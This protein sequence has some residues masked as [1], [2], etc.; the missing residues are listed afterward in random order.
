[1]PL[2]D[3]NKRS[4]RV[5]TNLQNLDLDTVTFA[6]IA[7]TGNTIAVE[8]MNE[9]EMRRLVLVNLARLVCAGE[10]TG[11]LEAGGGNGNEF[12]AELTK[13]NWDGDADPIRIMALAPFGCNDRQHTDTSIQDGSLFWF[14]FISPYTGTVS[15]L[16]IYMGGSSGATGAV[17]I[18]FYSD[19]DGVPQTFLGEF[20][21]PTNV[22]A[23][24]LTQTVSSA[25]V[26]LTRGTQFWLGIYADNW[27]SQ[28]NFTATDVQA[29]GSSAVPNAPNGV[30][31]VTSSMVEA[32][33]SGNA[34]ITDWTA[35]APTT[36]NPINIG[37]KF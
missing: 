33:S 20:V 24:T 26:D 6:N 37:V 22:G 23:G 11:L 30:S 19:N 2:P 36:A 13:Y 14:P 34:T 10:W 1:M 35:L 7:A 3:A 8:E 27:E 9:D 31:G 15:E 21:I 12:N 25:D 4:P 29:S 16:D 5:Y 32:A 18:G 28:A 17:D